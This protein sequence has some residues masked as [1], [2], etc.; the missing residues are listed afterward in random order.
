MLATTGVR[1][2]EALG[3][4]WG[5][6]D[7]DSGR[8]SIRRSLVDVTAP[9]DGARPVYSDPKTSAAAG[10]SRSTEPP[11]RPLRRR[12]TE[13]AQERLLMGIGWAD[14]GLVFAHADGRP[15][16]PDYFTRHFT[17]VVSWTTLPAIRVHDLRHTW[18][19]LAREAGVHPKVVSERLGHSNISITLDTYSHV[20][21]AK[22]TDAA[23]RVAALI[24]AGSS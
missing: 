21:P 4:R 23:D 11:L 19:T 24:L 2:G 12:R 14:H 3:L 8:T 5:A 17:R 1:R 15:L 6:V 10:P 22:Q 9:E 16:H 20:S 13:Q 7:L 18:A